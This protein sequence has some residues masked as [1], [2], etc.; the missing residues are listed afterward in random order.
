MSLYSEPVLGVYPSQKTAQT[1][2]TALLKAGFMSRQVI[3]LA[4][5]DDDFKHAVQFATVLGQE[6]RLVMTLAGLSLG[7]LFGICTVMLQNTPW[8][9]TWLTPSA[10]EPL[11]MTATFALIGGVIGFII[12]QRSQQQQR[13]TI[14]RWAEQHQAHGIIVHARSNQEQKQA[15][16]VLQQY[17]LLS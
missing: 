7:G 10:I 8:L 9:Q 16:R 2:K 4:S 17:T 14:L 11:A 13:A 6:R 1:V 5:S 12:G 3:Y 15:Q